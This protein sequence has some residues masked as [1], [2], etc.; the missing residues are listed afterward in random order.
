[1]SFEGKDWYES[2]KSLR[3][4]REL[5]DPEAL[6]LLA[7]SFLTLLKVALLLRN[8]RLPAIL[9]D[10]ERPCDHNSD[11]ATP[12]QYH[13]DSLSRVWRYSHVI[14]TTLFR[15]RRPCLLRSLVVFRYGCKYGMPVSIHFGVRTGME[16][17]E[18]HSWVTLHGNPL[19]ES[20]ETLRSYVP[21]YSYP[22]STSEAGLN[23]TLVAVGGWP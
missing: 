23:R 6:R 11:R 22:Q 2:M 18:G 7:W 4:L 8:R 17:L 12:R 9:K 3:R 16:G 19:C 5:S 13:A 15:S 21:V 10:L 20:E 14:V 1:M